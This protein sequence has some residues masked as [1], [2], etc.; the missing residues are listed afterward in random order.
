MKTNQKKRKQLL[1]FATLFRSSL[2]P[3]MCRSART[4]ILRMAAKNE[5]ISAGFM[6]PATDAGTVRGVAAVVHHSTARRSTCRQPAFHPHA[7]LLRRPL[8]APPAGGPPV[9]DGQV[10]PVA[11]CAGT[12]PARCEAVR[13]PGGHRW[14]AGA[15]PRSRL[16]Q[17][18][19]RWHAGAC[20]PARNRFSLEPGHGRACPPLGGRHHRCL[21]CCHAR[22]R[23]GR[24][25]GRGHPP[26][27]CPQGW[28]VLRVQRRGGGC[29][30]DA[31][32]V[33]PRGRPPGPFTPALAGG[34][35]RSGCTPGQWHGT[36]I[37]A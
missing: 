16:H 7:S 28:R 9:S 4:G 12:Q 13:G 35:R 8:C 3:L 2:Y 1:F 30:A 33:C 37:P 20:R 15:G 36:D 31:G 14:R 11:R 32:R 18:R 26:C 22:R 19:V 23:C 5:R 24:Q 6:Q 34:H 29:P 17:R 10:P 25:P 27:L 21:P